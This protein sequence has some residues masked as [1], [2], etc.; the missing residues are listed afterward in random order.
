[1]NHLPVIRQDSTWESLSKLELEAIAIRYESGWLSSDYQEKWNSLKH[2][3]RLG[4]LNEALRAY[5]LIDSRT[6][7]S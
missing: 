3:L 7:E 1:M 5:D 6:I 2:E 4:L